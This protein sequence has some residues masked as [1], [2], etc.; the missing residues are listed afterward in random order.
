MARTCLIYGASFT[1][2]TYQVKEF[3]KYIYERT[4]GKITLYLT[5]DGGAFDFVGPEIGAGLIRPLRI[6][7][8]MLPMPIMRKV[9]QGYWLQGFPESVETGVLPRMVPLNWDEIGGMFIEGLTSFGDIL[10]NYLR[11]N[12]IVLNKDDFTGKFALPI[13]LADEQGVEKD[14]QEWF[15]GSTW[16]H[17][18]FTQRE[19]QT[20]VGNFSGLPCEMVVMTALEA[21]GDDGPE[22]MNVLCPSIAGK[23]AGPKVPAWFNS[24]IH[25]EEVREEGKPIEYRAHFLPYKDSST[26]VTV[27]V[28]NPFSVEAMHK[29]K[30]SLAEGWYSLDKFGVAN[31]FQL[32]DELN[33]ADTDPLR[34]WRR[35]IDEKL[36][37]GPAGG[38]KGGGK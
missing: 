33:V 12:A 14:S 29:L 19:L 32:L 38:H 36:G 22:K 9:S 26:G 13:G 24:V 18:N 25:H 6:S 20:L 4:G 30:G 5:A 7:P 17:Y 27:K 16:A 28:K 35:K 3:S 15:S 10:M 8:N 21:S 34:E 37:R 31:Y 23:K 11:M 2:K 1:R